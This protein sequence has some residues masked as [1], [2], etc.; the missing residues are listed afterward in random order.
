MSCQD[1]EGESH[2]DPYV[3]DPK[4][5]REI[6]PYL[7]TSEEEEDATMQETKDDSSEEEDDPLPQPGDMH[8][9]FKKS[10]LP[11]RYKPK[12]QFIPSHFCRRA[13]QHYAK[14]Y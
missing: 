1:S 9:E 2:V 5:F 4:I 13:R 14:R 11:R 8:V 7:W 3:P 10:S 6:Y 12:V